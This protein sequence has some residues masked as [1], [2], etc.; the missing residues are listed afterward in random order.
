M[1]TNYKF[2]IL[3]LLIVIAIIA[4]LASILFP[5]LGRAMK[6][7]K[8][9]TCI[10]NLKQLFLASESYC[11]DYNRVYRVPADIDN[12]TLSKY[13]NV[14][15]IKTSYIPPAR[16]CSA[17]DDAPA[18]TPDMLKCS[19]SIDRRGWGYNSS[20][21]YGINDYLSSYYPSDPLVTRLP[22]ERIDKYPGKTC[23]FG[24]LRFYTIAPGHSMK[25]ER[26]MNSHNFVF[27][28]GH[29]KNLRVLEI[30]LTERY[31]NS[32]KTYFWRGYGGPYID[33]P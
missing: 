10:N 29:A 17:D 9:M 26:H 1:K 32:Y 7:A 4:I 6:G 23:Y 18:V 31:S 8:S 24:D 2:T 25:P 12:C 16:G 27:L 22:T 21:D 20:T 14:L 5:A 28:D 33:Y 15:L 13:W 3:E 11:I 19:G 30:P